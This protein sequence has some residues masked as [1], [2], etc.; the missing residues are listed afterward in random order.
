MK[1]LS[2]A[3]ALLCAVACHGLV[4]TPSLPAMRLRRAMPAASVLMEAEEGG[5]PQKGSC[6]W[7][8]TEKG[9]ESN[10]ASNRPATRRWHGA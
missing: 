7:F 2:L 9:C 1:L 6:K 4:L 3:V 5:T 8:N 10:G